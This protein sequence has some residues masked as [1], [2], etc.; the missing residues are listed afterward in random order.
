MNIDEYLYLEVEQH[1]GSRYERGKK[2]WQI[3]DSIIVEAQK[4]PLSFTENDY[5]EQ[6]WIFDNRERTGLHWGK[7][8]DIHFYFPMQVYLKNLTI[9]L[10]EVERLAY[11]TVVGAVTN[12]MTQIVPALEEFG[13]PVLKALKHSPWLPLG[14]LEPNDIA[15]VLNKI[16]KNKGHMG[17]ATLRSLDIIEKTQKRKGEGFN[18]FTAGFITPWKNE[19][20]VYSSYLKQLKEQY[21]LVS[22]ARPY[23]PFADEVV[24][25]IVEPA[26]KFLDGINV[27]QP[28]KPNKTSQELLKFTDKDLAAP[29]VSIL[30]AIKEVRMHSTHT[31][32]V[33]LINNDKTFKR[34]INKHKSYIYDLHPISDE[35]R[36]NRPEDK[37]MHRTIL[38]SWFSKLFEITQFAAVWIIAFSTGLRNIDLRFLD[39]NSCLHYSTKFRIWYMKADLQKTKNT[40]YIPIGPPAVKALKLLNWLRV[41]DSSI[42]IQSRVFLFNDTHG[43]VKNAYIGGGTLNIK[44]KRFAEHYGITLAFDDA[45]EG[46]CHCIRATLAGYIGRH[47]VL[48][49]LI[50]K[51][52]FGH[53]NNLMPDRYLHHNVMVTKNR[54]KTVEQMHS[55]F[56]HE[57]AKSI[58]NEEVAGTKGGE[59]L[60]GAVLLK[61]KI[62]LENESLTEIDVHKKLTEV[63]YEIILND[64]KNEQTQT[65]LTPMGVICMR[66]TNHS[67][68]S[69]CA[70]TINKA[71]RDKAG[72]SRAMFGALS[73]LPNPAQCIGLDCPDALATNT[74]SLPL[75]EQFDWYTN[76]YRQCTD[77]NRDMD[78]DARHFV[79]TYY[80]IVM[81][82]DMLSE[83]VLFRKKYG[84][85]LRQLY[86]D[87]KPEGYFDV[88]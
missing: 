61:E 22:E 37:Q 53:S 44:L 66:A 36:V 82:N 72:V 73:Q 71:E 43:R 68:D 9:Y 54:D 23:R 67:N 65:L 4:K 79:D 59:L 76:V 39:A 48:A 58:V 20:I 56:A 80:P 8:L 87:K 86:V 32:C 31:Q 24:A 50:L 78:D 47:S 88:W 17:E 25:Q 34:L 57:I 29:V 45:T 51:K 1:E 70:A 85:A 15:L 6:E 2:Q 5:L 52:L 12:F 63:L 19:G 13:T 40:I 77:K 38:K 69:P 83:A 27:M 75:L 10:I 18:F 62:R 42:L 26:M 7:Y 33:K 41:F 35:N 84:P 74:H 11:K 49:V 55:K 30:N 3:L 16:I 60:R 21:G 14:A 64:I 28:D 81:A 46:T